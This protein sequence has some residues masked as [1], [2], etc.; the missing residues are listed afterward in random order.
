MEISLTLLDAAGSVAL[1][2]WGV[3]MVQTG[4]QR[5][6][7][8]R[9]RTALGVALSS[10]I[11][12]F[13]AGLGVTTLLQSSTA[14]GLMVTGFAT[15]GLVELVPALAV[16]LGA[17]VGTTLIVQVL[18]FDVAAAAPA[19]ILIGVVMFRRGTGST[20]DLGRVLIGLGLLL[21]SLHQLLQVMTPY[22]AMP[23]LQGLAGAMSNRPVLDVI[24]A[25][26]ITW[27][28]H[29]SV[30]VVLLVMAFAAKGV[31]PPVAALA[32]VLGANLGTAINPVLEG[33]AGR[34]GAARRVPL[35]N[36]INRVAGIVIVLPLLPE[37]TRLMTAFAPDP[38]RAVADFHTLF[39]LAVA[40]VFLPLLTPYARLLARCFPVRA[41]AADPAR[42][43][44]LDQV[45]IETPA[46]AL[47]A[48]AREALRLAD[49]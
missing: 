39:N 4:V 40:A 11:G 27:A 10:R 15:G 13:M 30:A 9:L 8:T 16:M 18:S 3:R 21:V 48:A 45:A 19:L 25:A 41:R 24:I 26:G 32:F 37:V 22:E 35:G 44:Y 17:N 7:G 12:A 38:A 34:E 1:L 46:V 14:T 31:V 23:S 36:L 42:P 2:L 28:A 6:F 47:G 20:R 29:S 33:G 43:M 49:V 5:A